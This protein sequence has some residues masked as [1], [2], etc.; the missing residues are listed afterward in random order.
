MSMQDPIADM[1]I[2]IKNAQAVDKKEVFMQA[3]KIKIAIATLLKKEGYILDFQVEPN[4]VKSTLIIF[5]KYYQD[6]PVIENLKRRSRP[7]L[8]VYRGVSNLPRVRDGLGMAIISTPKGVMSD[9]AAR[10]IGQG[11]EVIGTVD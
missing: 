9:K 3:S 2:R 10:L 7:G 6:K 4:G 8:R 5:L 1:F 11:G